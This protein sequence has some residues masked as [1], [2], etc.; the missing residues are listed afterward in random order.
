MW[1]KVRIAILLL[2]LIFVALNTYFD[3]VYSTD[4]DNSLRVAVYPI[5]GDGSTAA[6][7]FIADL[8]AE[9]LRAIEA[10]FEREARR[11]A[12][13]LDNPVRMLLGSQIRALPPMLAENAGALSTMW[14]SLRMRFWASRIGEKP[15]GFPPDVKLFVLFFDPARSS[16]LPHS[17]GLQK[18]LVGIVNAFADPR[19]MGSNDVVIAHELLHTLGATDKYDFATSLPLHPHGYAEPAR[20]PLFPQRD[21]ELMGGRIPISARDA[22]I[23][24]SLHRVRIGPQTAAEIGWTDR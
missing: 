8:H 17:I 11:Y 24:E 16:R 1:R 10:F 23:P 19:M 4:W 12:L 20:E 9:D 14:W 15:S 18:G 21:A 13:K 22:E 7:R 6:E 5:N 2:I 3:R